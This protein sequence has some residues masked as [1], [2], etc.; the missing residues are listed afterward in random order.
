MATPPLNS[1]A[2]ILT[3]QSGL[4]KKHSNKKY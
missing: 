2:T 1:A 4:G 3:P